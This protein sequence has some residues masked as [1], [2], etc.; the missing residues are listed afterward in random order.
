MLIPAKAGTQV[1]LTTKHTK[2][3]KGQ[4]CPLSSFKR[5]DNHSAS[6]NACVPFFTAASLGLRRKRTRPKRKPLEIRSRYDN[7]I[8]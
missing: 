2:G 1:F 7:G 5:V 8:G 6:E 3:A 4:S